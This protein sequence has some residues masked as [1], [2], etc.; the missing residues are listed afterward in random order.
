MRNWN[1]LILGEPEHDALI[2]GKPPF[3]PFPIIDVK[4][5]YKEIFDEYPEITAK[6]IVDEFFADRQKYGN[7]CIKKWTVIPKDQYKG[8]LNNFMETGNDS[9][10]NVNLLDDWIELL[11]KNAI[12]LYWLTELYGRRKDFPFECVPPTVTGRKNAQM[13][14]DINGFYRWAVFEDGSWCCSDW[15]INDIFDLLSRYKVNMPPQ[16]KLILIN[17]IINMVHIRGNLAL[18]FVEGGRNSCDEISNG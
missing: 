12:T 13:F 15:S 7:K 16:G 5:K 6:K 18:A 9:R 8:Q 14:L 10:L 17:R 2:N 11:K 3:P 4:S 1:C